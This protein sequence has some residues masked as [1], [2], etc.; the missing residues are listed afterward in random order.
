MSLFPCWLWEGSLPRLEK[1]CIP[2]HLNLSISN[3]VEVRRVT[4]KQ[5][6]GSSGRK[7][8]LVLWTVHIYLYG[9]HGYRPLTELRGRLILQFYYT[10]MW[11]S[12]IYAQTCVQFNK[13]L[14]QPWHSSGNERKQRTHLEAHASSGWWVNINIK[15][16]GSKQDLN[17]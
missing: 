16:P 6:A 10:H 12:M 4:A 9:M 5:A 17:K 7:A 13:G 15:T 1:P 11:G 14:L 8:V 3:N 2:P